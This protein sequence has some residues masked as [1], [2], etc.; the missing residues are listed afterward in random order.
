MID[1]SN[2]LH[3]MVDEFVSNLTSECESVVFHVSARGHKKVDE[4][5]GPESPTPARPSNRSTQEVLKGLRRP[6]ES[7]QMTK[8]SKEGN[9][10]LEHGKSSVV[11]GKKRDLDNGRSLLQPLELR[12][13][14]ATM[15]GVERKEERRSVGRPPQDTTARGKI[16][17]TVEILSSDHS[18]DDSFVA[19]VKSTKKKVFKPLSKKAEPTT[20]R[21][22]SAGAG[23]RSSSTSPESSHVMNY[24]YE[25]DSHSLGSKNPPVDT[26]YPKL[27]WPQ[28]VGDEPEE[29]EILKSV[30]L[31]EAE[32]F[33]EAQ[34][35]N[36]RSKLPE[37]TS[38]EEDNETTDEDVERRPRGTDTDVEEL[39]VLPKVP[40]KRK[41]MSD[42]KGSKRGTQRGRSKSTSPQLKKQRCPQIDA[43]VITQLE[44]GRR[45]INSVS[46]RPI[47]GFFSMLGYVY[48]H[49]KSIDDANHEVAQKSCCD[50][51]CLVQVMCCRIQSEYG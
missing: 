12:S 7:H 49:V 42:P 41:L 20:S 51:T 4:D 13:K 24:S 26:P 46:I 8:T 10:H 39:P 1:I 48:D 50:L 37:E 28:D 19:V 47:R 35:Q 2:K 36:E 17:H 16:P 15:E 11:E 44:F 30:E 3:A 14:T 25:E 27:S 40:V 21:V 23:K 45:P 29:E 9:S 5:S 32:P 18:S 6:S 33:S 43:S 31:N 22:I 38:L 34:K